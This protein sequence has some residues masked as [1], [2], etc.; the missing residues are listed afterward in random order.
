MKKTKIVCTMGPNSNDENIMR[1]LV[2][3][4]MD[5][6]RFN[7]SHGS[8]EEQKGRMDMLK[9][10]REEEKKPVA[11]LLD[12]KGPEIRTGVLKDGKK[13]LLKEGETIT[14]TNEEIE[15]DET[16]VSLTYKGLVDDVQIGNMILIDDGLIG[17]KEWVDG[18]N[19]MLTQA[20]ILKDVSQFEN[21]FAFQHGELTCLLY[22]F[23]DVKLDIGKLA[24][25]RLQTHEGTQMKM[26]KPLSKGISHPHLTSSY[27]NSFH[28]CL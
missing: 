24:L 4:G 5:I 25:W 22:P 15:G 1:Q 14:L 23:D 16:K 6:A 8:H 12:T 17:L 7:F 2:K 27:G 10:I 9:K 26:H 18:I 20:G 11:I 13:V 28:S 21:V 3:E 19:E